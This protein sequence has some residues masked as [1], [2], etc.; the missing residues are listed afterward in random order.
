MLTILIPLCVHCYKEQYHFA[1]STS[2]KLIE[3]ISELLRVSGGG[4]N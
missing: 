2:V 4:T 1:A 3:W